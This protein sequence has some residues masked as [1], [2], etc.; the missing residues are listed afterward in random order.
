MLKRLG[1]V[2]SWVAFIYIML[3][4]LLWIGEA[5][6][7]DPWLDDPNMWFAIFPYLALVALDYILAGQFRWVPWARSSSDH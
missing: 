5:F 2:V 6:Q 3:W 1:D 4:A 7:G